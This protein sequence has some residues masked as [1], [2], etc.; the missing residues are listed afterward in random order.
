[1]QKSYIKYAGSKSRI[2]PEI[3]EL[4]MDCPD[5][6]KLNGGELKMLIEPFFGSG[7]VGMNVPH[8]FAIYNDYNVDVTN[9][10]RA[11]I[12]NPDRVIELC[13]T[14][15]IG[16]YEAYYINR[17]R[18]RNPV[19]G[20]SIFFRAA[21][22]IYLN[23]F[24]FNGMVRYNLKGGYNVPV[25]KQSGKNP[26]NIPI[27][28]INEFSTTVQLSTLNCLDFEQIMDDN[29][30]YESTIYCDPPYVNMNKEGEI[31]YT[32]DGF[33][34]DDQKRLAKAAEKCRDNG[35]RVLISNHDLP[36]TREIYKNASR[37]VEIEAFRS[38]SSKSKTRGKA[39]ELVAIYE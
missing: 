27:D 9:C 17:E 20:D 11:V 2:L 10:H 39:K 23:R 4:L 1:M 37:I 24:G 26:P 16:G 18:F 38:I 32:S 14:L 8:G 30:K 19:R 33:T 3:K 25:G 13:N 31:Q 6:Y 5:K 35:S 15:W 28:A 34:M 21:L 7:V 22:F 29:L 36:E 12:Q